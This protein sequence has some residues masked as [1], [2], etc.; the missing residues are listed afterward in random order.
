MIT[1]E[2][3][4]TIV[5]VIIILILY[6]MFLFDL[7]LKYFKIYRV[8]TMKRPFLNI[9]TDT[10]KKI[11]IVFNKCFERIYYFLNSNPS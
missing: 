5:V 1:K 3:I 11:N 6:Y 10:D 7:T 4:I 8:P 2:Y 9:Y